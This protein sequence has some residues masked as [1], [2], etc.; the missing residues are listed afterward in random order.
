MNLLILEGG[1]MDGLVILMFIIMFGPAI[2][3]GIIGAILHSKKNK[4]AAKVFFILGAVYIVISL[5][6]CGSLMA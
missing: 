6:V 5:G 4:K 1:N 3:L 2:F